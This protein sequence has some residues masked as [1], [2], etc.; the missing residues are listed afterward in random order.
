MRER[1][2]RMRVISQ[3]EGPRLNGDRQRYGSGTRAIS[4]PLRRGFYEFQR[5]PLLAI[6]NRRVPKFLPVFFS[7]GALTHSSCVLCNERDSISRNSRR[8]PGRSGSSVI[9]LQMENP[10]P[11]FP[12]AR[13]ICRISQK[14]KRTESVSHA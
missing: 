1:K 7:S 5:N 14:K 11:E 3:E 4:S 8:K 9:P 2:E 12:H 6:R 13:L 10:E